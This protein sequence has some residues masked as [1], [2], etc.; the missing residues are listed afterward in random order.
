M[1]SRLESI[2]FCF[3]VIFLGCKDQEQGLLIIQF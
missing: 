1:A 2:D 3:M